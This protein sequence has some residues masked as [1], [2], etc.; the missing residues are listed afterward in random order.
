MTKKDFVLKLATT[1]GVTKAD[2]EFMYDAF[3]QVLSDSLVKGEDVYLPKVGKIYTGTIAAHESCVP[4]GETVFRSE[5]R[6]AR[7]RP[8]KEL[9]ERLNAS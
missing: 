1:T 3:L 5:K 4:T 9:K 7:F 6:Q 2:S 8:A